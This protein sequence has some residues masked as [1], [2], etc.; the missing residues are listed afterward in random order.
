MDASVICCSCVC[1]A[2]STCCCC[3]MPLDTVMAWQSMKLTH[4]ACARLQGCL[5]IH[6]WTEHQATRLCGQTAC[7]YLLALLLCPP[8]LSQNFTI[9]KQLSCT[10]MFAMHATCSNM[11]LVGTK[12]FCWCLWVSPA[13]VSCLH[14]WLHFCAAWSPRYMTGCIWLLLDDSVNQVNQAVTDF[15][16]TL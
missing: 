10:T 15:L 16:P 7:Y 13:K 1:S 9:T 4:H 11:V 14:T 6:N 12:V 2:V 5:W 8:S 3:C